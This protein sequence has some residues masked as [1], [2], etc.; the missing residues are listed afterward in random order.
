MNTA[1]GVI[2]LRYLGD[3]RKFCVPGCA[4]LTLMLDDI[5]EAKREIPT[6]ARPAWTR[7]R[8]WGLFAIGLGIAIALGISM[9]VLTATPDRQT[10]T[11]G[12]VDSATPTL[13]SEA[14]D[15]TTAAIATPDLS[16]AA[17]D[18]DA[19][20]GHRAYAEADATALESVTSDG[21]IKLQP[22]AAAQFNAM[23]DAA[24]ADGVRLAP[25][26]GFRTIAQQEELFFEVKAQRGQSPAK[27][28]EVSAPP[29]YSEHHTGYAVDVVDLDY[30]DADLSESFANT[31][32]FAWLEDN[33]AYYGF[34]LSFPEDNEQGVSY[35]PWHWRFVGDSRS[36]EIFYKPQSPSLS[37]DSDSELAPPPEPDAALNSVSMPTDA[38]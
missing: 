31:P 38:R 24:W 12:A 10:A 17:S 3:R 34:E 30:P 20:L 14:S 33:A 21:L 29:G 6:A 19:L 23:L 32:G 1:L 26:S 28:A 25:I 27:R 5:P 2:S 16:S 18:P 35:E 11:P 36:L 9:S 22:T 15:S 4:C 13:P 7:G 37:P 8:F